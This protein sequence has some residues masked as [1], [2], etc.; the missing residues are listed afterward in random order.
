MATININQ[1]PHLK[2]VDPTI[3]D[4]LLTH[5]LPLYLREPE[6]EPEREEVSITY[7]DLKK[8]V[9]HRLACTESEMKEDK[10]NEAL[11]GQAEALEM[12]L[13]MMDYVRN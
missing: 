13:E 2:S 3:R 6:G 10:Y 5:S 11:M 12:V 7:G 8:F 1:V 4:W 9:E